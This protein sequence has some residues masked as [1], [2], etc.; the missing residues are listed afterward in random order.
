MNISTTQSFYSIVNIEIE[1]FMETENIVISSDT[2]SRIIN[3]FFK[4]IG[5]KQYTDME[6]VMADIRDHI[7][8]PIIVAKE[9]AKSRNIS[10]DLLITKAIDHMQTTIKE[11]ILKPPLLTSINK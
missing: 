5:T 2:T 8:I 1:R 4:T 11:Y 9:Y 6:A 3:L 7:K 10:N